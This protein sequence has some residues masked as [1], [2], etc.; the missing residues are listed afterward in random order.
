MTSVSKPRAPRKTP[1]VAKTETVKCAKDSKVPAMK[2]K[3][4]DDDKKQDVVKENKGEKQTYSPVENSS[5]D[6]TS[7]KMKEE[8]R[9]SFIGG[10]HKVVV[11]VLLA[12]D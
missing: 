7:M 12:S 3:N 11:Q 2:R 6:S 5:Q 8:V 4:F 10:V 1:S 9:H